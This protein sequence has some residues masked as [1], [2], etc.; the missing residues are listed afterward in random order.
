MTLNGVK[1]MAISSGCLPCI[2]QWQRVLKGVAL[3][4]WLQ[5]L[6][7][8]GTKLSNSTTLHN[9]RC[10]LQYIHFKF[11][12]V[13]SPSTVATTLKVRW[14]AHI[15]IWKYCFGYLL[16]VTNFGYKYIGVPLD[17]YVCL[18]NS[19]ILSSRMLHWHLQKIMQF[20]ANNCRHPHTTGVLQAP[21]NNNRGSLKHE[22]TVLKI[23]AWPVIH[24]RLL[25]N[26]YY[27]PKIRWSLWNGMR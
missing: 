3:I 5:N 9:G 1:P 20:C 10:Y 6:L 16:E 21:H 23:I 13:K 15:V 19:E 24:S 8:E 4:V 18:R 12:E 2:T 17:N 14:M 7:R 27:K 26:A 11:I 25:T 22:E